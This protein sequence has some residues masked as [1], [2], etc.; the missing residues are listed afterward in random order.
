MVAA[1]PMLVLIRFRARAATMGECQGVMGSTTHLPLR[2]RMLS[3]LNSTP[4]RARAMHSPWKGAGTRVPSG[5]A[6]SAGFAAIKYSL[7]FTYQN[8]ITS[9][10]VPRCYQL[11]MGLG[12]EHGTT[13]TYGGGGGGEAS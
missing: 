13:M 6:S 12:S 3:T 5:R 2:D 8:D 10:L 11:L 7:P 1:G 4:G 9:G